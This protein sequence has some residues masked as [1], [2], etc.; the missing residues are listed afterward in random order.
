ML[1]NLLLAVSLFALPSTTHDP[2]VSNTPQPIATQAIM[3]A[4]EPAAVLFYTDGS[5][6]INDPFGELLV[7][8]TSTADRDK[9]EY[10]SKWKDAKNVEHSVVTPYSGR[11]TGGRTAAFE[12][13]KEAVAL[14]Q[15]AYPPV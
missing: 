14:M 6:T 5:A 3:F 11:T 8:I 13:H 9:Q 12:R 15:A 2:V 1:Q 4:G 7:S 10:V